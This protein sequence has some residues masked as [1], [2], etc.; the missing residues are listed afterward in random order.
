[1]KRFI[2]SAVAASLLLLAS[3]AF[4]KPMP[5]LDT[6]IE[7]ATMSFKNEIK[8]GDQILASAKGYLIFPTVTKAGIGV[9]GEYGKGALVVNGEVKDYYSTSAASIGAQLGVKQKSI[10]IS[11]MTDQ[12]LKSFEDSNGW[13]VGVDGSITIAEIGAEGSVNTTTLGN[14]PIVAYVYGQSGLMADVSLS[15]SKISKLAS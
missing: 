3:V 9:G 14:K 7:K 5:E 6:A 10:V 4:A 15:G 11:F 2:Q 13:E 8:G 1:M 12:A